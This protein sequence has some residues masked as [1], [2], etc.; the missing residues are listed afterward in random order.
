MTEQSLRNWIKQDRLDRYERDDGL[1]TVECEELRRL[2][3]E[4]ARLRQER[5]LLK[6]AA[7]F[8]SRETDQ[9]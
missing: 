2:S 9:R 5:D 7:A 4:N 3:C 8:F 6:L 1:T